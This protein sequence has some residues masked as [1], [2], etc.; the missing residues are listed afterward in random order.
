MRSNG[1][2]LRRLAKEALTV[3]IETTVDV[4]VDAELEVQV[5]ALAAVDEE[6]PGLSSSPRPL[7][8][9]NYSVSGSRY[10]R[11]ALHCNIASSLLHHSPDHGKGNATPTNIGVSS[12]HDCELIFPP[13]FLLDFPAPMYQNLPTFASSKLP[14]GGWKSFTLVMSFLLSAQDRSYGF[15]WSRHSA[16]MREFGLRF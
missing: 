7:A 8:S 12:W 4:V 14:C 15:H 9:R 3:A 10:S 1:E 16:T 5:A 13:I 2:T 6:V 11:S